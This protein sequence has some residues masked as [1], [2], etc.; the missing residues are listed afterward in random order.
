MA[1][2][3]NAEPETDFIAIW[4]LRSLKVIRFGVI[5]EQLRGYIVQYNNCGL[6]CEGSE[7]I[8]AKEAKSAIYDDLT[9]ILRPISSEPPRI[10]T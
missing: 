1:N 7:D 8:W 4:P 6:Y 9:L 10:S 3:L 5:E 2:P